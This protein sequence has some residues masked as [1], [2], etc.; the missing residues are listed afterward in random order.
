MSGA[1][2]GRLASSFALARVARQRSTESACPESKRTRAQGRAADDC[3][4]SEQPNEP[5]PGA[6]NQTNSSASDIA[7]G[8]EI[9]VFRQVG[10]PMQAQLTSSSL[11]V[12]G[13]EF[14]LSGRRR[15]PVA[16]GCSM[17]T[18]P[19]CASAAARPHARIVQLLPSG[20]VS[21]EEERFAR[22]LVVPPAAVTHARPS[23]ARCRPPPNRFRPPRHGFPRSHGPP[24]PQ[25][26]EGWLTRRYRRSRLLHNRRFDG[27]GAQC[28]REA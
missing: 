9:A 12:I 6:A 23:T 11:L 18:R 21:G 17:R 1:R 5:E 24:E 28:L 16:R 15:A 19:S 26:N 3:G 22:P 4:R 20:R 7:D 8:P 2:R 25:V 13:P 10:V 27:I 14:N